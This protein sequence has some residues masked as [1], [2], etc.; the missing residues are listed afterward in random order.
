MQPEIPL[1][2]VVS[3][4]K[5]L[6]RYSLGSVALGSLIVSFV[7][8]VRFILESIRRKMKVFGTTPDSWYGKAA[9]YSSQG[10]L[11]CIEWTVK[12]VNRNAYIMVI[13]EDVVGSRIMAVWLCLLSFEFIT[14]GF[15]TV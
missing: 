6:V 4:M 7:E 13:L 1:L 2:P 14:D 5:R 11:R 3:S 12:S 10:I 15:L 8:S 9:F